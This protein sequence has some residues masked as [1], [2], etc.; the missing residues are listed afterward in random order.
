MSIRINFLVRIIIFFIGV[1]L[2]I[3]TNYLIVVAD[4]A[5]DHFV[6]FCL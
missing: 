2:T 6:F 4:F 5:V 3:I 1:P